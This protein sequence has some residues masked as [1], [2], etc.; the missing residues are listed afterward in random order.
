MPNDNV[1]YE[2][3][4]CHHCDK[5]RTI[6]VTHDPLGRRSPHYH[7]T[8]C[9]QP[10]G[11]FVRAVEFL[12][13]VTKTI[14]GVAWDF[15]KYSDGFEDGKTGQPMKLGLAKDRSYSQGYSDGQRATC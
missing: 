9:D 14:V 10:V 2:D 12:W 13:S 7:C 11:V 15:A 1:T 4:W 3:G 8:S 6:Q 5:E